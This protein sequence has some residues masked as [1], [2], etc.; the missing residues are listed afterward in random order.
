MKVLLAFT[1]LTGLAMTPS[2]IQASNHETPKD[3]FIVET[4]QAPP[5]I[6]PALKVKEKPPINWALDTLDAANFDII[7]DN[8][9]SVNHNGDGV[10]VYVVDGGATR[11][12]EVSP[13]IAKNFTSNGKK[14]DTKECL[15]HGTMMSSI[16]GGKTVGV[17]RGV[18]IVSLRVLNCS[19]GLIIGVADDFSNDPLYKALAWILKHHAKHSVVNMSLSYGLNTEANEKLV[20]QLVGEGI[21]VI[22]AAG[23]DASDACKYSPANFSNAITVGGYNLVGGLPQNYE[24]SN[25]GKC[26]DI[27]APAQN[28]KTMDSTHSYVYCDGTSA[29]TAYVSGVAALYVQSHPEASVA[30]FE[31]W[32]NSNAFNYTVKQGT[33]DLILHLPLGF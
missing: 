11:T 16:I 4:H 30:D 2:I 33:T 24:F 9:Y 19:K 15:N 28:V 7:T 20:N 23:N 25:Y 14:S 1:L 29:A 17:A 12:Q 13:R 6:K 10:T 22:V 32:L 21:P 31:A 8:S 3:G 27:L 26:V 5:I 18:K